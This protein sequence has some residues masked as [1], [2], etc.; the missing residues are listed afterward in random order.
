M[1][2]SCTKLLAA[3]PRPQLMTMCVTPPNATQQHI[4]ELHLNKSKKQCLHPYI[5]EYNAG[6]SLKE[7]LRL[8]HIRLVEKLLDMYYE[9]LRTAQGPGRQVLLP[10][11]PLPT[12]RTSNGALVKAMGD[13]CTKRTVINYRNRLVKAGLITAAAT[14]KNGQRTVNNGEWHGTNSSYELHLNP[15]V[16]HLQ[17]RQVSEN[18][19]VFFLSVDVQTFRHIETGNLLQ[20]TNEIINKSGADFST[21]I[22]NQSFKPA[23][24]VENGAEVLERP[25]K[26]VEKAATES[27]RDT[28]EVAATT[29]LDTTGAG[30]K[31]I[32][33]PSAGQQPEP[34]PPSCAAPP[35]TEPAE[36]LPISIEEATSHL[37]Q[38]DR[39][40]VER[41]G[42]GLWA[43]AHKVLYGDKWLSNGVKHDAQVAITEYLAWY[44]KPG[45]YAKASQIFKRRIRMVRNWLNNCPARKN[46]QLGEITPQAHERWIPLPNLYF[47]MRND[48]N[49]FH[50]T[51]KWYNEQQY[52]KAKEKRQ[53]ALDRAMSQYEKSL[54]P[55]AKYGP[56][57]AYRKITQALRKA[58]GVAILQDFNE[59]VVALLETV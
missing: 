56:D 46:A 47:D 13:G 21:G 34:S 45:G 35:R 59:R 17:T 5:K 4:Y 40:E 55:G 18:Q 37:A 52:K 53:E 24:D 7:R 31:T 27:A 10:N 36:E 15:L 43:Y 26:P 30:Y 48:R 11:Q 38:K 44:T 8:P 51:Q 22:D 58:Y 12:L 9:R 49:G 23:S 57:Q 16:M 42:R 29:T 25:Q 39:N 19:N 14:Y 50:H 2:G 28:K 3:L 33:N 1:A 6:R 32:E 41:I 54:L 20:D